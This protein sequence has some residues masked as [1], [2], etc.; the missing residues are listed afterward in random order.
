MFKTILKMLFFSL[1][2]GLIFIVIFQTWVEKLS[3]GDLWIVAA[4]SLVAGIAIGY[5]LKDKYMTRKIGIPA[6]W[7]FILSVFLMIAFGIYDLIFIHH[8]G[9]EAMLPYVI[10]IGSLIPVYLAFMT[11]LFMRKK[12]NSSE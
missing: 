9:M 6:I 4:L 12:D 11:K 10:L 7:V 8:E 3:D 1:L 2:T 5:F